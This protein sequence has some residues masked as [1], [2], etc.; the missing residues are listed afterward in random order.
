MK[1]KSSPLG[2]EED[3]EEEELGVSPW[4]SVCQDCVNYGYFHCLVTSVWLQRWTLSGLNMC[5]ADLGE[6]RQS[7]RSRLG[8]TWWRSLG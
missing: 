2:E 7:W 4:P 8:F 1:H 6:D 3:K 5:R